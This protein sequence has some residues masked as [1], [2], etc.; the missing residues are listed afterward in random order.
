[1]SPPW[2]PD[3]LCLGAEAGRR[4]LQADVRGNGGAG[5][6]PP[7]GGLVPKY[8]FLGSTVL[9]QW[10]TSDVGRLVTALCG[11]TRRCTQ[12]TSFYSLPA[13]YRC[14]ARCEAISS[15]HSSTEW[16]PCRRITPSTWRF[17]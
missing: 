4:A 10:N 2:T 16:P 14:C 3:G 1:M 6:P 15:G 17:L 8:L 7:M 12:P 9:L 11:D 13:A 5:K